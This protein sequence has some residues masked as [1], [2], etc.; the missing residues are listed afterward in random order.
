MK[1]SISGIKM[2][3]KNPSWR[4]GTML[5]VGLSLSIGWGIRGNFGHEHGAAFAGCLA[6][7][8]VALLSGREDWRQRVSYFA[9]FGALGWGLGG[10][11]SYMQVMSYSESGQ[12]ASQLYGYGCL[13]I[14]GFLWA[15]M[16]TVGTAFPAVAN[17]ESLTKIFGPLLFVFG[18]WMILHLIED[19]LSNWLQPKAIFDSTWHRHENPLYWFD[20]N[21]L[22]AVFA[23]LGM[24]VYDLWQRRNEGNKL[25]LPVFGIGGALV[26][27][28]TQLLLRVSGGES[29]FASALTYL[30]GDPSYVSPAT[31]QPAYASSDLL[32]NWPQFFSDYPQ[33]V[34]WLVGL[35]VGIIIYFLIYGKFRNGASFF[36]Y[37]AAGF[38]IA[39]LVFPVLGGNLF[40]NYGGLRM[41]PP[42]GDNWAGMLGIFIGA[43]IWLWR[44]KLKSVAWV[45]MIGGTI[46]G[47]GFA[48]A[49]FIKTSLIA[50]GDPKI[51]IWKGML[52]GTKKY[53]E[54]SQAWANWESQNWH[55]FFEQTYGFING[56]AI[57]IALALLAS[58]VKMQT[59]ENG[60]NTQASKSTHWTK[61]FS[62]L[63]VL[64]GITYF[65]IAGN[66]EVWSKTLGPANWQ[67]LITLPDGSVKTEAAQWDM[68]LLG[69]VPGINF[70]HTS[71]EGWFNVS[72][73]LLVIASLVIVKRHL[74][75]PIPVI[76]K[77]S[78]GKGQLIFLLL[79][80]IM[81]I[82]NFERALP[83]FTPARL[84]TEWTIFVNA[85]IAT[86][87]VLLLPGEHEN[88]VIPENENFKR[89]YKK[90]L[91]LA[92]AGLLISAIIFAGA[93]RLMYHYPPVDKLEL[94]KNKQT[95][96]GTEATWR[97]KPNLKNEKGQ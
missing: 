35:T 9:F 73:L 58:R 66:V 27:Y 30:Q 42:R 38:L 13:F 81:V 96:F 46:G 47:L 90:S 8:T 56:I 36:V 7:I 16:G 5:L 22:S 37:M 14:M 57:A 77:T 41:T 50:L 25:L 80:W 83:H 93:N 23:L 10:S 69:G 95:R 15:A 79:L 64:L 1:G 45:S 75:K 65:N 92:F 67:T 63:F 39:F 68:P 4:W 70:L 43:S 82:A 74:R 71:P 78:L 6:A 54:I 33:H 11:Q 34:G 19:P 61:I 52:P 76:P 88:I 94:L 44:N 20:S 2:E 24:G 89:P 32:N 29:R 59:L 53:D 28:G 72:W 21:Y 84:L 60:I 48:G 17:K 62:T 26:G 97:S 91:V 87:L 49:E 18:A 55:S 12:A 85:L 3:N 40:A 86:V 31:G 51:L